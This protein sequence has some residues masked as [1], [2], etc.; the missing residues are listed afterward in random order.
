MLKWN[1]ET[2]QCSVEVSNSVCDTSCHLSEL[3]IERQIQM[4]IDEQ[5]NQK[6]HMI[7]EHIFFFT[8]YLIFYS[9]VTNFILMSLQ[10][11]QNKLY[12]LFI[13]IYCVNKQWKTSW[14]QQKSYYLRR[15][16]HL[17]L[18]VCICV[19]VWVRLWVFLS[20]VWHLK[21][22]SISYS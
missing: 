14:Y 8:F 3:R 11:Y 12:S 1:E 4:S 18:Y 9:T 21:L 10:C 13:L 2:Q 5:I 6:K 7:D 20:S 15:H 17:D 16:C 22:E 19:C